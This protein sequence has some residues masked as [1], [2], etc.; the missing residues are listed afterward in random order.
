MTKTISKTKKMKKSLSQPGVFM[1]KFFQRTHQIFGSF[2]IKIA[3]TVCIQT[4][5]LSL[6]IIFFFYSECKKILLHDLNDHL[7]S[8]ARQSDL[9]FTPADLKSIQIL[10]DDIDNNS[11]L[12][13]SNAKNKFLNPDYTQKDKDQGL[14][15]VL[16]SRYENSSHYQRVV[17][18][19]REIRDRSHEDVEEHFIK[20]AYLI[21]RPPQG[22]K[23]PL[24]IDLADS[25]YKL[26]TNT[27]DQDPSI[28]SIP[29]GTFFKMEPAY[30]G[31]LLNQ[32]NTI[33]DWVTDDWGTWLT[34]TVPVLNEKGEVIA[35]LALDYDVNNHKNS[36]NIILRQAYL[37]II[38][39]ILLSICF[40]VLI[41]RLLS[42][43]IQLLINAATKISKHDF[44][45]KVNIDSDDQIG[46]FAKVF[47]N[48]TTELQQYS[49]NL[50]NLVDSYAR[51]VPME[52]LKLLDLT[53]ILDVKLGD[54][55]EKTM[56]VLFCD[57]RSFTSTVELMSPREAFQYLNNYMLIAAPIIREHHGFIDKFIGDSIMALFPKN[58]TDAVKCSIAL[59]SKLSEYNQRMTHQTN[60]IRV[61]MGIHAGKLMLGTVGE[62]GRL[63][64]TVISDVVNF[65]AR[66]ETTSKLLGVVSIISED[67]KNTLEDRHQFEFRYL[68]KMKTRGKTIAIG[69]YELLDALPEETKQAK[70]KTRVLF[71]KAIQEFELGQKKE[72][73]KLFKK[74][75]TE[76]PF[77]SVAQ[78]YFE[79]L[80]KPNSPYAQYFN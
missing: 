80:S 40:A 34:V 45:A 11:Q 19:L 12:I 21:I 13:L 18:L 32:S 15:E 37:F 20:Y 54:Q 62:E 53:S 76:Y 23:L 55:V 71:E 74:I 77:D 56:T 39:S 25:S 68:G 58:A 9:I 10:K 24:A 26:T 36:L 16:F 38:L 75:I 14:P 49:T 8:L 28:V 43:P 35:G 33:S 61:A 59:L 31:A 63:E 44:S 6:L 41:S 2:T 27:K 1:K 42:K 22:S 73:K 57:L 60:P 46:M 79:V 5:I 3:L 78:I 52:F 30:E 29:F 51:F 67:A 69:V 64:G 72:A 70:I 65:A 48:M 17:K 50:E 47:N 66:L 4:V 7:T